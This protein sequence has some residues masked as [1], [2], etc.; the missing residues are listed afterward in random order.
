[1][2]RRSISSPPREIPGS[3]HSAAAFRSPRPIR[4]PSS[5]SPARCNRRL[6]VIGPEAPLDAGVSDA[7]ARGGLSRL[8]PVAGGGATRGVEALRQGSDVRRRRADRWARRGTATRRRPELAVGMRGAPVVVKASGLAAGKGV[9]VATTV[10]EAERAIDRM[11]SGGFGER[12]RRSA[13]RG[14]HGGRGALGLRGHRRRA[15][16]RAP[17]RRR[18]TSGCSRATRDRTPAG[19]ERTLR[20]RSRRLAVSTACRSEIIAPTLAEMRSARDAVHRAAVRGRDAHQRRAEGRGVQLPVRRSRRRRPCC[21]C[22][23]VRSCRCSKAPRERD[24][25]AQ[26]PKPRRAPAPP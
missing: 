26:A 22:S 13:R 9:I 7:P 20:L 3:P 1:M 15:L 25:L 14:V 11:F 8:R 16:R 17:A 5:R 18:I 12:G 23:R 19:W 4:R 10:D 6:V 2:I 24:G 21:R